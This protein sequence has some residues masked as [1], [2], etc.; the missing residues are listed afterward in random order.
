[1]PSFPP[2]YFGQS[3]P[4]VNQQFSPNPQPWYPSLMPPVYGQYGVTFPVP[5]P[6]PYNNQQGTHNINVNISQ[7]GG[8]NSQFGSSQSLKFNAY[9]PNATKPTRKRARSKGNLSD[10]D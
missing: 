10:D 4:W 2:N 1:M 6:P 7:S 8:I 9:D 3:H 5:P